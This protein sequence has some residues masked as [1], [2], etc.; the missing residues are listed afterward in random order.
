M[1]KTLGTGGPITERRAAP[2]PRSA[3]RTRRIEGQ[4]SY[5]KEAE[6][7]EK[8]IGIDADNPE[9][10]LELGRSSPGGERVRAGDRRRTSATWSLAPNDAERGAGSRRSIKQ[11]KQQ[12]KLSGV[13]ASDGRLARPKRNRLGYGPDEQETGM[14]FD[15]K[16]EKLGDDAYV[17]A[18]AGEVDLYT[19]PEFKEQLSR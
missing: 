15:I 2:Q 11:L 19:A 9:F 5:A 12:V 6:T 18:L 4:A 10:F 16:T 3:Y 7:W 8:L 14:N 13:T 1:A 17:I